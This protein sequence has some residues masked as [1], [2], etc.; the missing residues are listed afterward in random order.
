MNRITK[1]YRDLLDEIEDGVYFV[2]LERRITYW[3]RGAERITGYKA[4]EV[5]GHRCADNILNHVDDTGRCLCVS[6]CPLTACMTNGARHSMRVYLHH[7]DGHRVPVRVHAAAL[8]DDHGKV[9]GAVETFQDDSARLMDLERIRSLERL[10]FLDALTGIA[11]RRFLEENLAA[12][13][14]ERDRYGT[15]FGLLMIDIDHFKRINDTHGHPV[16]DRV[17]RMVAATLSGNSRPFDLVARYGGEEFVVIVARASE[18]E[19]GKVAERYRMLV[20]RSGLKGSAGQI[21]VTVSIGAA[22]V[23]P[24][25]RSDRL[26]ARVDEYLYQAKQRGRNRVIVEG[27][28]PART[29]AQGQSRRRDIA[30]EV[31]QPSER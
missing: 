19:L 15:A 20:S 11:N 16:G 28:S 26:I 18:D 6:G 24:D 3:N 10:A 30:L 21:R 13:L 29:A 1:F 22:S 17:L 31:L 8:R 5:I 25:D 7:K 2:D 14:S 23:R 4:G 27:R 9:I 12:R